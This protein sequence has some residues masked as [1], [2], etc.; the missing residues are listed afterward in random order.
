MS[1]EVSEVIMWLLIFLCAPCQIKWSVSK[2]VDRM[3]VNNVV[4]DELTD[5]EVVFERSWLTV[6]TLSSALILSC[7]IMK[8]RI[9]LPINWIFLSYLFKDEAKDVFLSTSCG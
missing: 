8:R 9:A 7:S 3:L 6:F 5:V 4:K 1:D 2:V